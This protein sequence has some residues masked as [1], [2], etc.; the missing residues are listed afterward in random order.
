MLPFQVNCYGSKVIRNH[1]GS[2]EFSPE[3]DPPGLSPKRCMEVG[4][5]TARVLQET[6]WR[7]ARNRLLQLVPCVPDGK[8]LLAASDMDADRARLRSSARL[9]GAPGTG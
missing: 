9:I 1:G 6:P 7:V 8:D 2:E 4:A 5:A 3:P